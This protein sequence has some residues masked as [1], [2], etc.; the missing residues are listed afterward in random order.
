MWF[1]AIQPTTAVCTPNL[2][3]LRSF[4]A[5]FFPHA[6]AGVDHRRGKCIHLSF[7]FL[8][9]GS[10]PNFGFKIRKKCKCKKSVSTETAADQAVQVCTGY[11]ER[12]QADHRA[13]RRSSHQDERTIKVHKSTTSKRSGQFTLY[14]F[15]SLRIQISI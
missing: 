15:I 4:G 12:S 6:K 10:I 13:L 11:Q 2:F 7:F 14:T 3:I 8:L 5:I 1:S 9:F